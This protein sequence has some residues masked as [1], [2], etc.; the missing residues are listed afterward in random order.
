MADIY[1]ILNLS[2]KYI[3]T[4]HA[5]G[6]TVTVT[7]YDLADSSTVP[8]T[9][10]LAIPVNSSGHFRFGLANITTQPTTEKQYLAICTGSPSAIERH[11]KIDVNDW[12]DQISVMTA[13]TGINPVTITVQES[14]TTPI[15]EVKVSIEDLGGKVQGSS[16]TNASGVALFNLDAG[17]YN[18]KVQKNGVNFDFTSYAMTVTTSG[19]LTITGTPLSIPVPVN[20][21]NCKIWFREST[22]GGSLQ[23]QS[24]AT[25]KIKQLPFNPS[26]N[27]RLGDEVKASYDSATQVFYWEVG[28]GAVVTV[29]NALTVSTKSFT[30]PQVAIAELQ[31][32]L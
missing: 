2:S 25:L 31:S 17:G 15:G 21:D 30:V 7:I 8:L 14:D 32:L 10:N 28:K 9:S 18:V 16:K 5:N 19:S 27:F 24:N 23:G 12:I 29:K 4:D 11:V 1:S 22:Q 13:N 20:P 6:D 3:S 26:N